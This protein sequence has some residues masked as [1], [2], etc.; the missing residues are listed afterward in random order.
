[1]PAGTGASSALSASRERDYWDFRWKEQTAVEWKHCVP[2]QMVRTGPVLDV[3][4]GPGTL[5]RQLKRRCGEASWTEAELLGCDFSPVSME[6]LKA[7]GLLGLRC[8]FTGPLPF[9]DNSFGTVTLIDVLEH[10]FDP[11]LLLAEARRLA[12]EVVIVVPNFSSIVARTQAFVGRVPE[13]N[14]PQKRHC[15]W[16]NQAALASTVRNAGLRIVNAEFHTMLARYPLV[17]ASVHW[18]TR[19][20]PSLFALAFGLRCVRDEALLVNEDGRG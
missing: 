20:R 15:Y 4:C 7:E 19:R 6:R 13:N 16:F 12:P 11:A 8:D 10:C 1:M 2:A 17:G 18:M 14:T 5:L 9:Q 3:G